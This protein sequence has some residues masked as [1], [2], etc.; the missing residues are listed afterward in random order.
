MR[1]PVM[2]GITVVKKLRDNGYTRPIVA[3]TASGMRESLH[4]FLQSGCDEYAVKPISRLKLSQLAERWLEADQSNNCDDL[5]GENP[6][7]RINGN[8]CNKNEYIQN[9]IDQKLNDTPNIQNQT[10]IYSSYHEDPEMEDIVL[11]YV[12]TLPEKLDTMTN[13]L[14]NNDLQ[15]LIR[16][17]HGLHGSGGGFGFQILSDLGGK[18]EKMIEKNEDK[19]KMESVLEDFSKVIDKILPV[20]DFVKE[21]NSP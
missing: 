2:D 5:F 16:I 12:S 4:D 19:E 11:E 9:K 6:I 13:A 1:M 3:L 7:V 10:L 17:A 15:S 18:L 20:Y 14:K 21:I 8:H